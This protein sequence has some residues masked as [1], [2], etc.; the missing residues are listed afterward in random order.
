MHMHTLCMGYWARRREVRGTCSDCYYRAV[1]CIHI[2]RYIHIYIYIH[3]YMYVYLIMYTC[4]YEHTNV[5]RCVWVYMFEQKYT[6]V[7]ICAYV[8]HM[9][10]NVHVCAYIRIPIKQYNL[11]FV[12]V[13]KRICMCMCVCIYTHTYTYICMNECM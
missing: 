9:M 10:Y 12:W 4:V 1:V 3:I 13:Y 11:Y 8:L 5:K 6:Y 7:Y 2:Y